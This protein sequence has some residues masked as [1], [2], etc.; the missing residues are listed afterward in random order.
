MVIPVS[1]ILL[2]CWM[3]FMNNRKLGLV[4]AVLAISFVAHSG[5]ALAAKEKTPEKAVAQ[6]AEGK[7]KDKLV[8]RM[9]KSKGSNIKRKVCKTRAQRSA[10]ATRSQQTMEEMRRSTRVNSN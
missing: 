2:E 1:V 4:L 7:T 8:C 3:E 10:D 5:S 6:Q 9:V